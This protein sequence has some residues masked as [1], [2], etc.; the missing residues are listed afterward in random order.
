MH[1]ISC[2]ESCHQWWHRWLQWWP[3][4]LLAE[5]PLVGG[6][7]SGEWGDSGGGDGDEVE[8]EVEVGGGGVYCWT[9]SLS[10]MVVYFFSISNLVKVNESFHD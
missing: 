6:N 9:C 4:L 2:G 7:A 8:V 1:N 5:A 3:I 10:F